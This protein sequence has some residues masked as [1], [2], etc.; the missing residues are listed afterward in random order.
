MMTTVGLVQINN[1]FSQANY[2]PLSAGL[3][4]A[5]AQ[6][7]SRRKQELRFLLPLFAR[8][9]VEA[10]VQHLLQADVVGF[11]TYVWNIRLTLAIA[12][13]LKRRKPSMLVVF[14]G[15][16]VPDRPE[17]FLQE[18]RFIDLAVHGEGEVVFTQILDGMRGADWSVEDWGELSGVTYWKDGVLTHQPKASRLRDLSQIP[19][20]FLGGVFDPLME[21]YPGQQWLGLWETNRG[22]PFSCTFCD[23]GS[24]TQAKV[25]QF[26]LERLKEE[27]RWFA[28]HKIEFIFCCDANFGILPRD[29]EIA[30]YVAQT[31]N[32]T[33]YPHALSVQN[34]KNATERA[35][36]VQKT[37]ADYGLN[38]GVT[39]SMQS[40]D[41]H[42]LKSI[43]R[44]NISLDS[45]Q[46]LQRR[47]TR[48]RIETYCDMIL[49]LPGETYDS[50]VD[51]VDALITN[52]QHNR[53]QFNNLAILPNAE[54]GDPAYQKKYG[55][56][57]VEIKLVNIHGSLNESED[58]IYETQD[59]VICTDSMPAEDWVRTRAFCWMTAFLHFD[60]VFQIPIVLAH[61]LGGAT[62]RQILTQFAEIEDQAYPVL[63]GI[64]RFFRETARNIQQGETEYVRSREWLN[65]HWP[66]DEYA[67]IQLVREGRLE[68]F[69]REALQLLGS[70]LQQEIPPHL[71]EQAAR[72]NESL[73]K[74]PFVDSDIEMDVDFNVWEIY[75]GALV[76]EQVPLAQGKWHHRID[77]TRQRWSS[78]DDWCREV[79]WF[80]NKKGAYLYGNEVTQAQYEGHF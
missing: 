73:L 74:R 41:R 72:L 39:L 28:S 10:S 67:L 25:F 76:G 50:F 61:Q 13:E 9:T 18:H 51:G 2:L 70:C 58:G 53:V 14:G 52:G 63:S 27:V 75:Q 20:P 21:A 11:S 34:T 5:Y 64:G 23:W 46:E 65:I 17:A 47:F 59:L 49:A 1:S 69:Y 8:Q 33:G 6:A 32:E 79:V 42:T 19:S 36:L 38:K 7:Q 45:Y 80:G 60:K 66:A 24:A 4:Q 37:L 30:Q 71:L 3:L 77:R 55:M 78:W 54:M 26:E 44:D 31:K 22:C 56:G 12:A 68:A 29:L 57:T 48:D 40:M 35:Y 15:P 16:Q 62:Y 43:K